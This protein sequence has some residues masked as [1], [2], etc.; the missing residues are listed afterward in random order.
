MEVSNSTADT[1]GSQDIIDGHI[2]IKTGSAIK[3]FT[4]RGLKFEDESTLDAD[5]VVFATG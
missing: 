5:V 4:Q 3:E 2:K 1:G